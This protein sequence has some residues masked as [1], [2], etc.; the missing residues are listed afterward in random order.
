MLAEEKEVTGH[1][2]ESPQV[3]HA[4]VLF[5]TNADQYMFSVHH[6]HKATNT[7]TA[8]VFVACSGS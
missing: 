8:S 1:D 4:T 7:L 5:I 6:K 2:Q 3:R